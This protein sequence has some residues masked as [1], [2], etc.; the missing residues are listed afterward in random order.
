MRTVAGDRAGPAPARSGAPTHYP[1]R[2]TPNRTAGHKPGESRQ[3]RLPPPFRAEFRQGFGLV[4]SGTARSAEETSTMHRRWPHAREGPALPRRTHFP[5]GARQ[6]VALADPEQRSELQIRPTLAAVGEARAVIR[7][8][9]AAV[10]PVA[11]ERATI[12]GSE[13]VANSLQYA[14]PPILMTVAVSSD[15]VVIAVQDGSRQPPI[16]RMSDAGDTGGRGTLI[17]ERLSERWGVDFLPNGK[18][19]WCVIPLSWN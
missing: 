1:A 9:L 6:A 16:P 3:C 12:C 14:T 5:L 17:V 18:R 8:A 13:L 4:P 7:T 15:R 19:V 2:T 10:S 11:A